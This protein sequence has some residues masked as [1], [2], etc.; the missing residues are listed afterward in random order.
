MTV[1]VV[2][3]GSCGRR[4]QVGRRKA[5]KTIPCPHCGQD[6]FVPPADQQGELD[7][8]G[9]EG[10]TDDAL[11]ALLGPAPG[12]RPA[13]PFGSPTPGGSPFASPAPYGSPSP[14]A[15]ASGAAAPA[16]PR[17]EF[18]G[19]TPAPAAPLA[20]PQPGPPPGGAY[21]VA[22]APPGATAPPG[23]QFGG[24]SSVSSIGGGPHDF[25]LN[26][27]GSLPAGASDPLGYGG[28]G[29]LPAAGKTRFKPIAPAPE[30]YANPIWWASIL[31]PLTAVIVLLVALSN[32]GKS[33]RTAGSAEV[34]ATGTLTAGPNG[35][36][37][38]SGTGEGVPSGPAMAAGNGFGVGPR[39]QE[40]SDWK[41]GPDG[42]DAL[43]ATLADKIEIPCGGERRVVFGA[44]QASFVAVRDL[45]E[46]NRVEMWSLQQPRALAAWRG[47]PKEASVEAVNARGTR[48]A[49][50]APSPTGLD[51]IVASTGMETPTRAFLPWSATTQAAP[52]FLAF[53]GDERVVLVP[54]DGGAV[55]VWKTPDNQPIAFQASYPGL[56]PKKSGSFA[57]APGGSYLAMF[58]PQSHLVMLGLQSG[59]ELGRAM[60]VELKDCRGLAFS[61]NGAELAAVFGSGEFAVWDVATG[62]RTKLFN[63]ITRPGHPRTPPVQAIG[64]SQGWLLYGR[65][66][67]AP[68]GAGRTAFSDDAE[69][70]GYVVGGRRLFHFH[71]RDGVDYLYSDPASLFSAGR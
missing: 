48:Y 44:S 53:A 30:W 56:W 15:S 5:G 13:S 38:T 34:V 52:L 35:A 8:G 49:C 71:N 9:D 50:V 2:V 66:V 4:F 10:A 37:G 24:F 41:V 43:N 36:A 54:A 31:V 68:S 33:S 47:L 3:C 25:G 65:D 14:S 40:V 61:L 58:T 45:S 26:A 12:A 64:N 59:E 69:G 63:T 21:P 22:G 70:P 7:L 62:K 46:A 42:V 28:S 67:I 39:G 16:A 18:Y 29:G 19:L 1:A 55:E 27:P 51:L 20:A 6:I 11:T 57:V 17:D 60:A 32:R 23:S